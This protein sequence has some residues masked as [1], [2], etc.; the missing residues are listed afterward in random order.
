MKNF[1]NKSKQHTQDEEK[2]GNS[3]FSRYPIYPASEDIYNKSIEEEDIDPEDITSMKSPNDDNR[4]GKNNE[5]DFSEDK[6]GSD[7]D[8]PDSD[9]DA[10]QGNSGNED[11]ENSYYSLGGDD[12]DDLDEDRGD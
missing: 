8:V 7:L 10:A 3:D 1:N 5:K 2:E 4:F 12:H 11:E 6:S 9:S